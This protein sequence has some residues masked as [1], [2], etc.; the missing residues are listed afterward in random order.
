M[1]SE[2]PAHGFAKQE[3]EKRTL[4]AQRLM[5]L[6]EI[7][8]LLLTTEPEVRYFSGFHTSFW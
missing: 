4:K 6:G 1:I 8:S 5:R 3:F 2:R 7:D